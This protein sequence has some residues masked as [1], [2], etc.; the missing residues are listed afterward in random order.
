MSAE[1]Y[2]KEIGRKGAVMLYETIIK[3]V[4]SFFPEAQAIYLFGTHGTPDEQ[5]ESD[6]DIA[7]LFPPERAKTIGNLALSEC[8]YALEDVF[9]K[10][11]DLI[12]IRMINTV[13]QHEIIQEGRLIYRQDNNAVDL[14][15]MQVMSSYQKLNEERAGILEEIF[16]S[17]RVVQ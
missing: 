16:E 9:A 11:V 5:R 2:S 13:F 3:T 4:Q 17:S 7:V 8:R 12:N 1:R 10:S 14:F 6:L 15:E